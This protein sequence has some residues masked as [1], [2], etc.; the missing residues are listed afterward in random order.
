MTMILN[1]CYFNLF[2]RLSIYLL[3]FRQGTVLLMCNKYLHKN[4][5]KDHIPETA[6]TMPTSWDVKLRPRNFLL[7]TAQSENV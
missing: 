1:M 6:S 7:L 5:E 3:F 4:L 2:C